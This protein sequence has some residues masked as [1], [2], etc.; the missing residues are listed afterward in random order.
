MTPPKV[1]TKKALL[2]RVKRLERAIRW[3]CGEIGTFPEEP[4]PLAGKYRRRYHWRTEL[5]KRAGLR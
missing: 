2:N 1:V 5:R 3:A 4:P